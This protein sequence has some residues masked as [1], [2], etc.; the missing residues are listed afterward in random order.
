MKACVEWIFRFVLA[1]S[2]FIVPASATTIARV[3]LSDLFKQ[4]DLVAVVKIVSGDGENYS[5]V[6]Y[7]AKVLTAFKGTVAK[8]TIFFGPFEGFGVGNEYIVFL[9]K[10]ERGMKSEGG[11]GGSSYGDLPVLYRIMYDGFSILPSSY[12][13]VF[14]GKAIAEQ[15]DYS[16]KLNPEQ[17]IL[18][19]GVKE[20]PP[21]E[22]GPLTNYCKWVRKSVFIGLLEALERSK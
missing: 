17:I 13:C 10:S 21:G 3:K 15:C 19:P 1:S 6:V 18:P 22:A 14:N 9:N 11:A 2:L 5:V 20:F 8:E 16:V 7:K 12:E 4:A